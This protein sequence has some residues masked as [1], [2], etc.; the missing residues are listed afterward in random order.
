[1]GQYSRQ[2]VHPRQVAALRRLDLI[3]SSTTHHQANIAAPLRLAIAASPTR[4]AYQQRSAVTLPSPFAVAVELASHLGLRLPR[5]L[6]TSLATAAVTAR[7]GL[8]QQGKSH[9][10]A[11]VHRSE[12][13][14]QAVVES[15][16]WQ[17]S[18]R[19]R[20][21]ILQHQQLLARQELVIVSWE[22]QGLSCSRLPRSHLLPH[23]HHPQL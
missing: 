10:L 17:V 2:N 7:M 11:L 5:V 23:R 22:I 14:V 8:T 4:P 15:L 20:Q 1:M 13:A 21:V 16:Q 9:R 12:G 18:H 6:P 3:R 19:L